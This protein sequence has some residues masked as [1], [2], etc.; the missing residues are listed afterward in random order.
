MHDRGKVLTQAAV[1]ERVWAHRG[2]ADASPVVLDIDATLVE[3]HSEHKAGAAAHFTG[4]YGFHP[5]L[6]FSDDG[7]ALG[8]VLRPGNAAANSI[9]DHVAVLDAAIGRL[10]GEVAAGHRRGDDAGAVARPVVLRGAAVADLTEYID[11]SNRPGRTRLIVRRE[12]R[13]PGAQRS[14]FGSDDWRY[15]G[16]WTDRTGTPAA[17][18][19]HM[20]AHAVIAALCSHEQSGLTV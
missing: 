6:C 3:V 8:A 19:A 11:T 16:H 2:G 9:D 15:W 17:C 4:G 7:D 14:L 5:L 12:P 13:H 20:R 1:R 10:P 18:D